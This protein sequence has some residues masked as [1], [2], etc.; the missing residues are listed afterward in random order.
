MVREPQQTPASVPMAKQA[1][2][3]QG[4]SRWAEVAVWTQRMLATLVRGVKGGKWFSLNDKV[5]SQENLE[6]AWKKVKRNHGA[7]GVD[8][9]T[10]TAFEKNLES[11]LR[12][13][14][15]QLRLGTYAPLP[16]LR[17]MIKK[18]GGGERPLGIPS[19]RDRV[20]QQ[21]LRHVMEPIFERDFA[22]H[23]YGFRPERGCKDALRRVDG[24]LK[25]GFIHVV[26]ADLKSYFD[27]IPFDALMRCVA[28][29]ISDSRLLGL[30]RQMLEADVMAGLEQWSPEA[31]CPQGAVISPLLSNI[32]LSPL[33]HLMAS[34]GFEMVRY[35]DDF[36]VLCRSAQ[37]AHR[38][39]QLISGWRNLTTTLRHAFEEFTV[40]VLLSLRSFSFS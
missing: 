23:S 12:Q 40:A 39:L 34:E 35:A 4:M 29:R 28:E 2:E 1:G 21:A 9:Q 10:V 8:H 32:Y 6:A 13:V 36:V 33:D 17:K 16:V 37:D 24:L 19:V 25:D 14:G 7:A 11:N 5:F 20:V 22:E 31:G 26:D 38:A 30:V 15:E 18:E 3:A 27:T